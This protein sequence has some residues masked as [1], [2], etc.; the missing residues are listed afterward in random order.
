LGGAWGSGWGHRSAM[1]NLVE[2]GEEARKAVG[3]HG[4]GN[5]QSNWMEKQNRGE[6]A[7]WIKI[8]PTLRNKNA[9]KMH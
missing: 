4:R 7:G 1:R 5:I 2:C 9:K 8:D 3:L 6:R